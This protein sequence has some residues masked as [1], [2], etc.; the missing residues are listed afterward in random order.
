MGENRT[1]SAILK[2]ETPMTQLT[3]IV[4]D[5]K[6][7]VVA[8]K[9]LSDGTEV[10]LLIVRNGVFNDLDSTEDSQETHRF[11]QAMEQFEATFPVDEGGD[12][13]SRAARD[14]ADWEKANFEANAE[15]LRRIVD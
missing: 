1:H 3:A 11:L 9:D 14:S 8:P 13:L 7:E 12:D 2:G 5:G 4:R 15:K 10:T 6:I